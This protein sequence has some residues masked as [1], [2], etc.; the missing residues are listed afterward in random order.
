MLVKINAVKNYAIK[1]LRSNLINEGIAFKQLG[2]A[3]IFERVYSCTNPNVFKN[4]WCG[5]DQNIE[6]QRPTDSDCSQKLYVHQ[7]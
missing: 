1:T 5:V 4:L 3:F 6:E 7:K 2:S